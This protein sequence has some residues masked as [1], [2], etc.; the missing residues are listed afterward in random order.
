MADEGGYYPD[1]AAAEEEQPLELEHAIGYTGA[2][3]QTL[4]LHPTAADCTV[5]AIGCTVVLGKLDD[6]HDQEFLR[7]HDEAIS[8]LSI[9]STGFMIA[10]GQVGS[11]HLKE[12]YAPVIVWDHTRREEIYFLK[13]LK[14]EVLVTAFSPDGRFLAAAD[15]EGKVL[16]WDMETGLL[17]TSVRHCPVCSTLVWGNIAEVDEQRM[18][19]HAKYIL[20]TAHPD[21]V[22][23]HTMAFDLRTMQYELATVPFALPSMGL[24]RVYTRAVVTPTD[25]YALLTTAQGDFAVFNIPNMIYRASVP[26]SS[27]GTMTLCLCKDSLYAGSGDG[28]LKKLQGSDLEWEEIAETSLAGKVTSIS[29]MPGENELLVGTSSGKMY[30]VRTVDMS[31]FEIA[32]SHTGSVVGAAFGARSD[33]FATI[34]DDHTVRVWDLS[35]YSCRCRSSVPSTN[36]T[37]V[38]LVGDETLVVGWADGALRGFDAQNGDS[39]WQL[40]SAHRGKVMDTCTT[41]TLLASGGEDGSVRLWSTANREL[42]VQF[43]EHTQAVTGLCIDQTEPNLLHSVSLDSTTV[44]MDVKR[45]R[46]AGYHL[47][48]GASFQ[49][50]SQRK[51]SETELVTGNGDGTIMFWDADE[52]APVIV[53]QHPSKERISCV[54]VSPSGR[55]LAS[56]GDDQNVTVWGARPP[57]FLCAWA[58][59]CMPHDSAAHQILLPAR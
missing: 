49:S 5:F 14:G 36:P 21:L 25:E 27:N 29:A 40:A 1:G 58:T 59:P 24:R 19:R 55:F 50:V 6:P 35:D 3:A 12:P 13:G 8:A 39:I 32:D 9:S 22:F 38:E 2:H 4:L 34:S 45:E 42:L 23:K 10:S 16:V 47:L 54:R 46:R 31:T 51:D 15:T 7:G 18:N 52:A 48:K 33:V 41:P 17:A 43:T 53:W 28:K 11:T 57:I 20:I 44:T 26:V 56:A 30:R 37:C